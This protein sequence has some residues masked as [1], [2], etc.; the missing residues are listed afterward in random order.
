VLSGKGGCRQSFP[1]K[2]KICMKKLQK[3][4]LRKMATKFV[5]ISSLT[6][7][8][9]SLSRSLM[10]NNTGDDR[11]VLQNDLN[12]ALKSREQHR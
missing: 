12:R 2:R 7:G 10:S 3:Y 5:G 4:E 9:S 11:R 8:Q 1:T 6:V